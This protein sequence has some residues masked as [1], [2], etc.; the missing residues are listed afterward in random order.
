MKNKSLIESLYNL[1][2]HLSENER[3]ATIEELGEIGV[4]LID[5]LMEKI[6]KKME[7]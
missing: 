1:L 7:D 5:Q 6:E 3:A 2:S 4:T